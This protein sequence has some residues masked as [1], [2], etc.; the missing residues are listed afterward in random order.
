MGKRIYVRGY[1]PF[2]EELRTFRIDRMQDVIAFQ[3]GREITIDKLKEFFSAFAA[4]HTYEES[5]M[6]RLTTHD[7]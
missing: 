3:N 2:R 6:L 5:E 4:D 7:G 1:C